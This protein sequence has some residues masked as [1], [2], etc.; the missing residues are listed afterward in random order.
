MHGSILKKG[1]DPLRENDME[2]F[3]IEKQ[4]ISLLHLK[5]HPEEGGYFIETYR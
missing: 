4:I 1:N 3:M 5:P 2:T